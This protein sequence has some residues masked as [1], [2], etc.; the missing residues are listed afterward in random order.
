MPDDT[1]GDH[2]ELV[3]AGRRALRSLPDAPADVI[4]RAEAIWPR[5]A[6]P[7]ERIQAL[8]SVDSWSGALPAMRTTSPGSAQRQLLFCAQD[9]D[10]DVRLTRIGTRWTLEGQILG[11]CEG[12]LLDVAGEREGE[13]S[14]TET[15]DA[16]GSFRIEG[17]VEGRYAMTLYASTRRIEFPTLELGPATAT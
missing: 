7:L 1:T 15:V 17:L 4:R 2:A 11:P 5:S 10:I 9:L 8:L 3:L 16:L 6:T 13:P 14:V 12:A